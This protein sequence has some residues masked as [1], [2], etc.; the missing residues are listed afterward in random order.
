VWAEWIFWVLPWDH[1]TEFVTH[2]RYLMM[3]SSLQSDYKNLTDAS[4]SWLVPYGH[5]I[6]AWYSCNI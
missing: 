6:M 4:S 2:I 3:A 1:V 5:D